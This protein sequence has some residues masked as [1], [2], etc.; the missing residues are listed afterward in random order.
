MKH[1]QLKFGFEIDLTTGERQ[2]LNSRPEHVRLVV[3]R[4]LRHLRTVHIDLL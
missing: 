2:G 4:S 1:R 3:E